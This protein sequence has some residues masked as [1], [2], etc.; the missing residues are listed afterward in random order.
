M[1]GGGDVSVEC[2]RLLKVDIR[3]QIASH[4]ALSVEEKEN[5]LAKKIAA[6]SKAHFHATVWRTDCSNAKLCHP[7]VCAFDCRLKMGKSRKPTIPLFNKQ[8][9][10][11]ADTFNLCFF[12]YYKTST[13]YREVCIRE[14]SLLV[15]IHQ[16]KIYYLL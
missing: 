14:S 8:L 2:F 7:I 3:W 16:A 12:L 13:S 4:L 9:H 11:P 10:F 15:K 1:M 6:L 5:E